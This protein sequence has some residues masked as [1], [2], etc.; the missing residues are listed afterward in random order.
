M[1]NHALHGDGIYYEAGDKLWVNLFAPSTATWKAQGLSLTQETDFPDGNSSTLTFK[2][3][4]PKTFTLNVRRPLWAGDGFEVR[5]NDE[6]VTNLPPVGSYVAVKREWNTGD[7]VAIT[8]PKTLHAEALADNPNRVALLWGPVVLAADLGTVESRRGRG[9][10]GQGSFPVFLTRGQPVDEWLKPV[11][12]KT[13]AFR[14]KGV[15]STNNEVTFLPFYQLSDHRYGIYWDIFTPDEWAKK[16]PAYASEQEKRRKLEA[17][18]V[19]YAQPGEMQPERDYH[20]QSEDATVV[21]VAE[22]PGRRG[23]KWFSFDLP[24]D[25]TRPMA[26]VITYNSGEETRRTFQ[27]LVDGQR[28]TQQNVERSE[29]A[30]FYDVEYAIPAGLVRGKQKVTVRFQSADGYEI[31]GIFGVRMIRADAE[32]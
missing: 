13:A 30:R 9:G 20:F 21:R 1:E 4:A 11:E 15:G 31:A 22:Q 7:R 32:R 8:L 18:T 16:S 12:G 10:R 23:T 6:V 26:L 25:T 29:P 14:A 27:I 24:V 17:A 28:L 2:L 19:G 5:V 3:A